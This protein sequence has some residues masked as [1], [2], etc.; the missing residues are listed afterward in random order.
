MNCFAV[1]Q[2]LFAE[3]NKLSSSGYYLLYIFDE[4]KVI[5]N[6][7][8]ERQFKQDHA[9][10]NSFQSLYGPFLEVSDLE[11]FIELVSGDIGEKIHLISVE[12]YNNSLH[13]S[14]DVQSLLRAMEERSIIIEDN[15][16]S[17][18]QKV[19]SRF[20]RPSN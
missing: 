14:Q 20:F 9:K 18:A 5:D 2:Y 19:W 10:L 16:Q 1:Y 12:E 15:S 4:K 3:E 17:K 13:E 8:L 11:K 6:E 7:M